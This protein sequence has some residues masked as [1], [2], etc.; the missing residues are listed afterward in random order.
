MPDPEEGLF[1]CVGLDEGWEGAKGEGCVVEKGA[2]WE[3]AKDGW[4]GA[5]GDGCDTFID[6]CGTFID[7]CAGIVEGSPMPPNGSC[8]GGLIGT[9][10]FWLKAGML[11]NGDG[12]GCGVGAGGSSFKLHPQY[13]DRRCRA[14]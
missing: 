4:D 12:I 14:S 8:M 11:A 1:G 13:Y 2:G 7:G 3:G 5:K 9:C 10:M 6:G